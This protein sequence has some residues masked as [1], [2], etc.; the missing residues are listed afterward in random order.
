[1]A[2]DPASGAAAL[3]LN[4]EV[5]VF[6]RSLSCYTISTLGRCGQEYSLLKFPQLRVSVP[7]LAFE[8]PLYDL[9]ERL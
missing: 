1:M 6:I 3:D 7:Q 9:L 4:F 5:E 2:V 8:Y